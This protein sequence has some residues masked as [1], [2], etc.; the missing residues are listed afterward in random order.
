[1]QL[2]IA[3]PP[4]PPML[5]SG[6]RKN[7]ASRWYG[8]G[9][10]SVKDRP[11][12]Q[13]PEAATWDDPARHQ[14]LLQELM[15]TSD[16]W[17]ISTCPDG[18]SAYGALPV[19]VRLL[20]WVKPNAQPGSHRI[21]GMW[22][23]VIIYP[24]LGRRSNRTGRGAVPDVWTGSAPRGFIGQKPEGYVHWVLDALT[25]DPSSDQVIDLF[26]GSGAVSSAVATYRP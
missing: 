10:R 8:T 3:D 23:P 20:A 5:G 4:Y 19:G 12:D 13:H 18:L 2:I 15:D 14:A 24:P 9:Q 7:R 11:A 6:G 21:R 26:P 1:M 16:G 22:E 25:Y 17:A